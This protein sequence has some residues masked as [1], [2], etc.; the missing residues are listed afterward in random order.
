MDI[1]LI[2]FQDS[3]T[4]NIADYLA[5]CGAVVTVRDSREVVPGDWD[6]YQGLVFSPGPGNPSRMPHLQALLAAAIEQKPVLGICL[7]F[8][9]LGYHYGARL[10]K[11]KPVHGKSSDLVRAKH[12]PSW[13]LEGVPDTFSVVRYHSLVVRGA[14]GPLRPTLH[15]REG[16]IMALEHPHLPLAGVQYHPEAWL[17]E[18]GLE[19]FQNWLRRARL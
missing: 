15:T 7:G 12:L 6:L 1:L 3:F 8:Q 5:R 18:W 11:G 2:D 14:A 10:E 9:A 13:L 16:E 17:S 4:W 19:L